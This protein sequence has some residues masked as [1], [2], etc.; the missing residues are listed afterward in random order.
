MEQLRPCNCTTLADASRRGYAA[1][2]YHRI[3]DQEGKIHCIF[4][5][6]KARNTPIKELSI[7]R[8]ELQAAVQATRLSKTILGELEE[9]VKEV[10]YWSDSM[11]VLQYIRNKTRRFNTY[12]ANRLTEIHESSTQD[13]WHFVPGTLNPADEG[14]RGMHS[15]SFSAKS[16]WL[17]GP[18]FLW[19]LRRTVANLE[20]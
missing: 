4:V 20:R 6:G 8:L 9:S 7:P 2:S 17:T 18:S 12:V 3:V 15:Q 11:M 5:M 1:V 10:H 19:M 14:S 16:R 13:Q